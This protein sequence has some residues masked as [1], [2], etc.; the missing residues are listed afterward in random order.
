MIE[1]KVITISVAELANTFASIHKQ[2]EGIKE[3]CMIMAEQGIAEK[4]E[5]VEVVNDIATAMAEEI[6]SLIDQLS[7]AEG[8]T[9]IIAIDPD[10][11]YHEGGGKVKEPAEEDPIYKMA[12]ETQ[13]E[14]Q[15]QADEAQE[16]IERAGVW[17]PEL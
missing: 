5:G 15:K 17:K 11:K 6:E 4:T 12:E 7:K 3:A 10:T 8:N 2:A 14:L 13:K 9:H 1:D 16:A